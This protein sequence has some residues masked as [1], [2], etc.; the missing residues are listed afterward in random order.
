[1]N[2]ASQQV[3]TVSAIRAEARDV[4]SVELRHPEGARLTPF[5]AGAHLE[6]RLPTTREQTMPMIRHYSLCNSPLETDRYVIA[7]GF[8]HA[9]RGGS[10]AVHET[11]RVGGLINASLPI[12]NFALV[13]AASHYRFVAGGIGITPI[14]S[15]IGWCEAQGKS[16]S[17][18]YCTRNRLRTAFYEELQQYGNRIHFHFADEA[19]GER[20]DLAMY[21]GSKKTEEHVYCCGP[22]SL[23]HSVQEHCGDRPKGS[24][25]L[26]WFAA[27]DR[28]LENSSPAS[29]FTV[30]VKSSGQRILVLEEKSILQALEDSG[31]A[32][33]FSCREGLCRTC[34]TSICAGRADHRDWV[35]SEEERDAQRSLLVCVSRAQ[36][37]ELVLDL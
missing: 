31:V 10:R 29:E 36:T 32:I 34:E 13:P 30:V 26:E 24:V 14:M 16:W 21:L 6:I 7:V 35:L 8:A 19:G 15:M 12:N 25:H 5:A 1:M 37:A 20:A 9:G 27:G 3:L 17:L 28:P 4:L 23:M 2:S 18:L 22:A 33:P 11:I